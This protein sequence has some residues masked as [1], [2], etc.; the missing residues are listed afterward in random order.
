[1]ILN[2]LAILQLRF[3]SPSPAMVFVR[4]LT[5]ALAFA[6]TAFSAAVQNPYIILPSDAAA[7]QEAVKTIFKESY[8]AYR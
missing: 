6:A 1:M 3:S 2:A 7:N 8:A 4:R 5:T